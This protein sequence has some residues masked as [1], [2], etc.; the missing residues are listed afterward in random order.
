M[1]GNGYYAQICCWERDFKFYLHCL[2]QNFYLYF[3]FHCYFDLI[4]F[5][6]LLWINHECIEDCSIGGLSIA[7]IFVDE[8]WCL[9]HC[10]DYEGG[11]QIYLMVIFVCGFWV[12]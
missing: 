11:C 4:F 9:L 12:V 8:P 5:S 1:S 2:Q 3:L 6:Y 10:Y 7:Q